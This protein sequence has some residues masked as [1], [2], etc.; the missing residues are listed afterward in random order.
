MNPAVQANRAIQIA[1]A[2]PFRP[3]VR[4]TCRKAL[5]W[6]LGVVALLGGITWVLRQPGSVPAARAFG[7]L[8][9]YGSLFWVT[10]AKVWWTAGK[11]AV[12]IDKDALAYQPLHTFRP[13]RIRLDRVLSMA[14]RPGTQALRLVHLDKRDTE[15]EFFLNL[16]VI[17]GRNEFL[18]AL[19]GALEEHGLAPTPGQRNSWR[20]ND[21]L[22]W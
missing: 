4:S 14:P 11:S 13:K 19:G 2:Y 9:L 12:T 8:M 16:G 22:A 10:L 21:W 17:E 1:Q 20:R 7:V 3:W 6:G 5:L 15:R 18:D